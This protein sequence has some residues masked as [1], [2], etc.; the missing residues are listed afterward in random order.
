MDM[1]NT[2][3]KIIKIVFPSAV[4]IVDRF[5]V[6]KNILEDMNAL[7][8][9]NKTEIKKDYLTEQEQAK[10]DRRQPKHQKY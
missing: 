10:I 7:I 5:H 2:M 6:M 9:K 3:A 8:T 1:A 4:Q